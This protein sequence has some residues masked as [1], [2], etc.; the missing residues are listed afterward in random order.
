VGSGLERLPVGVCILGRAGDQDVGLTVKDLKLAPFPQPKTAVPSH[1]KHRRIRV[2]PDYLI[3]PPV[4]LGQPFP[5]LLGVPQ[6]VVGHS[7]DRPRRRPSIRFRGLTQ[8][9]NGLLETGGPV[10]GE[11]QGELQLGVAS[12]GREPLLRI[13]LPAAGFPLRELT[14]LARVTASEYGYPARGYAEACK[15]LRVS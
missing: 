9:S 1:V 4:G 11:P 3:G 8:A 6:S 13:R 12:I 2:F 7:Q 14:A 5:G 15:L 10:I